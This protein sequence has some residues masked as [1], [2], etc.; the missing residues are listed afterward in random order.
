[1]MKRYKV[2]SAVKIIDV[3]SNVLILNRLQ[4]FSFMICKFFSPNLSRKR[5][6]ILDGVNSHFLEHLKTAG[7]AIFVSFFC[8]G[9]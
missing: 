3:E 6:K 4:I 2:E 1:M 8:T 9:K 5:W 7:F